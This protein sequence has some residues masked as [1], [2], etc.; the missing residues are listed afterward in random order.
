MLI[1]LANRLDPYQ[2][3]HWVGADLDPK[4]LT[5]RYTGPRSAVGNVACLT[6]D[7]C[8]TAVPGVASSIPA[9]PVLS[10]SLIMK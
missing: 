2:A 4:M 10:W 7:A 1:A 6:T 5:L 8:L 9:G 3:R